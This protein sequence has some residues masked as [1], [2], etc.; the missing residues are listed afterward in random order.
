MSLSAGWNASPLKIDVGVDFKV[1]FNFAPEIVGV[2][3]SQDTSSEF[4]DV[5]AGPSD[6]MFK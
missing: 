4:G 1:P 3:I 5:I 2:Q 6:P